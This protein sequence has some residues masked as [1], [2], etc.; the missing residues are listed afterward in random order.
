ME[1]YVITC[2]STVDLT[3]EDMEQNNIPYACFHMIANDVEYDDDFFVSY[4]YEKFYND[5]HN[6]MMPTTSQVGYGKYLE[7]FEPILE[8]GKDIIHIT[9]SGVISSDYSTVYNMSKELAEKYGRRI[10]VIDSKCATSGYG[11]LVMMA[12]HNLDN[13]M[14]FEDNCKWIEEYK[15]RI[16]HWFISTDLTHF[17]RGGR[18]SKAAGMVG[19]A[20][21]ICPLMEVAADGSLQIVEKIRTKSKALNALVDKIEECA[22]DG[23]DYSDYIYTTHSLCE[24]DEIKLHQMIKE[25]YPK[26]KGIKAYHVGTTIG[27]HT[28]PGA[29]G[30]FFV[31]YKR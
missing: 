7:M 24:E 23:K 22:V 3:K 2:T 8:S 5:I 16:N 29:I 1:N 4:P 19:S 30:V 25:R 14:S 27:A 20:L 12:K 9:L 15:N 13:G 28:G 17:I 10:V 26:I 11:M 18:V 21:R 6:G 31:G